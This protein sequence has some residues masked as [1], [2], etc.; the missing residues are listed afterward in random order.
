M[1]HGSEQVACILR[2]PFQHKA[3]D[4]R[5]CHDEYAQAISTCRS[6]HQWGQLCLHNRNKITISDDGG[7]VPSVS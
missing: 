1:Y 5:P 6:R 2:K 4:P 3:H 7:H